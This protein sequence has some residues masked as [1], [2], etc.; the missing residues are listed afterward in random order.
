MAPK[1]GKLV[2]WLKVVTEKL[3]SVVD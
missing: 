3:C 1:Q 2:I